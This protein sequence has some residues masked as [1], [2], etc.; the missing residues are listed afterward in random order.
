MRMRPMLVSR[1]TTGPLGVGRG[2]GT[3]AGDAVVAWASRRRAAAE[4]I[5]A[6]R[7]VARRRER[8]GPS[9]RPGI[10][11]GRPRLIR[12]RAARRMPFS[13][14]RAPSRGQDSAAVNGPLQ[15][16]HEGADGQ[17]RLLRPRP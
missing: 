15:L 8:R 16:L 14:V 9:R 13:T 7:I 1:T 12:L 3:G 2:E 4:I 5:E 6:P 10:L 17:G 11:A